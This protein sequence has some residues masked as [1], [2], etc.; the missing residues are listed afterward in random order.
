MKRTRI[1]AAAAAVLA[2]LALA[3]CQDFFTSSLASWAQRDPSVPSNLT[4]AQAIS[5]AD[6]AVANRDTALARALLPQMAA[7]VGGSPTDALIVSA[8]DTAVLATGIDDAFGTILTDIGIEALTDDPTAY[9]AQINAIIA[10]IAVDADALAIFTALA[11]ADPADMAAAGMTA[12]D[13]V[14]AAAALVI[15]EATANTLDIFDGSFDPST[16]ID[17]AV[18]AVVD[19]LFISAS[20]QWPGDTI[21]DVLADFISYT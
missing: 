5:I 14:A 7:F 8:V 12:A 6:L 4:P 10:G 15:S 11:A 18:W 16:D 1:I 3:S 20:A 2:S 13:Y 17:P 9:A 21:V 19:A